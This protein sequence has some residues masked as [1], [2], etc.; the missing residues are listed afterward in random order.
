MVLNYIWIAFFLIA[1][2]VAMGKLLLA[3][4][5]GV[6]TEIINASFDSAKTGFEISIGL[7][8][9]LSLWLGIMK[10]GERGGVIQAFARIASPV[11]SKLFPDLPKDHPATGSI[12]MNLSANLLG[13]DNAATPMGLKAMQELQTLNAQKDE[14]SNAMIMFLCINASGLT[15]IPIT[16][17]MYRAQLGAANASDV[18]LPIMLAT[19]TS[20][21]VAILAVCF[22]QRINILQRNLLLFFLGM[23]SLIGGLVLLF[24]SMDQEEVSLYSTLFANTL[25]FTIICGFIV[26]GMRKKINVYEAFIEG[27]KEGFK[28]AITIIPYLVAILVGIGVFRASGAM[29]FLIDSVRWG[30]GS[31]G[32]N[33]DFVE[34]LP[35]ILMKPLS[36][37]GARG[38][39]LDAMNT[40]GADSFVGRLSC[41]VQ[42]S[43]DTTF[44][45]VALYYGSVGIKNTRYTVPCALLADL[46]GAIAAIAMAYLFF[47]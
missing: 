30:V 14:A 27:A 31:M 38:M 7:T 42:G 25:L 15:L 17:M 20:T 37:S 19:F 2:I 41:I 18:F 6:F 28:T 40:Y 1:F 45:V 26:C 43:C 29:D 36:G 4:D 8:G 16:I 24:R 9:I 35:T 11:F 44:Y 46:A 3:G 21:L 13:L 34:A 23:G 22:K 12:F 5:T 10:I 39:M 47:T 32:L 33:T